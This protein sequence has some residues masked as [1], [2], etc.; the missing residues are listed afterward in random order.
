[1]KDLDNIKEKINELV[2]DAWARGFEFGV[3]YSN[4]HDVEEEHELCVGDVVH[5][6]F[7]S[8]KGIVLGITKT[9]EQLWA[10]VYYI[11]GYDVPQTLPME[12]LTYTGKHVNVR[13]FFNNAFLKLALQE[14]NN[15]N[16]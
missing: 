8:K 15:E 14:N 11:E 5:T 1:M 7:S 9:G 16:S 12:N 10:S 4:N 13:G 2:G 6:K 3:E